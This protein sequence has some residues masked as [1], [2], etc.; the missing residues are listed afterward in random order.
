[1]LGL[2]ACG[3]NTS[4][5]AGTGGSAGTGG[6]GGGG[7]AGTGGTG[8]GVGTAC[9]VTLDTLADWFE[10]PAETD[11]RGFSSIDA[12]LTFRN[13]TGR[14]LGVDGTQLWSIPTV[15][16]VPISVSNF[17]I[18]GVADGAEFTMSLVLDLA[19]LTSSETGLAIRPTSPALGT[20]GPSEVSF[21]SAEFT[22]NP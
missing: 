2:C 8:G 16:D 13:D 7:S 20:L 19:A 11:I 15:E 17:P 10:T 14:A 4:G 1:M 22:C 5:T 12:A 6:T 3:S 9:P 21:V 18:D